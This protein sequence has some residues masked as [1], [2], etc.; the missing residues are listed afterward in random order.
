MFKR[1]IFISSIA[2][3]GLSSCG[4]KSEKA[5]LIIH[6]AQS[7]N[8]LVPG[9]ELAQAIAIKDGKIIAIG[10]EREI[11]NAYRSDQS[12]DA[13]KGFVYPGFHDAHCHFLGYATNLFRADLKGTY[14]ANEVVERLKNFRK[15][16]HNIGWISGRG[17]D[18]TLWET[19][20]PHK[21]IL[22]KH[23]PDIPITI[24]RIDGH[25]V[26]ANSKALELAGFDANTQI[27]GGILERDEQ[28]LTG[29]LLEMAGEAMLELIPAPTKNEKKQALMRAQSSCFASGLT[30][31]TDAGLPWEDI[32]LLQEMKREGDL[33][34]GLNIMVQNKR[35]DIDSL[36]ASGGIHEPNFRVKSLKVYGDGS[37]GS[38]SACLKEHYADKPSHFGITVIDQDSLEGLARE[39]K[40]NGYQ[41]NI[42]SIGDSTS[43]MVLSAYENVLEANND[44]RWRIEH[45][46]VLDRADHERL[47][48]LRIIPSVQPTHATSDRRWA[49]QRVGDHRTDR[50]YAYK[51]LLAINGILPL[52]TDFPVEGIA[53]LNTFQSAV[54]RRTNPE[55]EKYLPEE[56]LQ[57]NEALLGLTIFPAISG[58]LEAEIGT[59]ELGKQGDIVILNR[60]LAKLDESDFTNL[61]IMHTIKGG[62]V[63]YSNK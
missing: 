46:Q 13:K 19:G 37:L 26:W 10:A 29:I 56:G 6:N 9:N 33:K 31:L 38:R 63:V 30:H 43:S 40:E 49:T 4:I 47:R 25:A 42:H 12:L 3:L 41:L 11:L 2:L 14:S 16:N 32:R 21:N 48:K 15:D 8:A 51:S 18:Q 60:D 36:I 62:E 53:P 20:A 61:H 45:S 55:D 24:Q 58:F 59:L 52:G 28:G 34:I 50:L 17:Y 35:P 5:D 7:I 44:M 54:F 57:K 23:F 22:D 27:E 39:A 1:L